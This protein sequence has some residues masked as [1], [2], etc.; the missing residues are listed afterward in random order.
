MFCSILVV[1]LGLVFIGFCFFKIFSSCFFLLMLMV[2]V[3]TMFCIM[4]V[5]VLGWMFIGFCFFMMFFAM[6]CTMLVV[7]L[8]SMLVVM[9]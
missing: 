4:L 1:V 8:S 3:F 2:V 6:F 7:L 9:L 5:V